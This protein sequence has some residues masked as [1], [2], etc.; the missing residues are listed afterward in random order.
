MIE[1]MYK[2]KPEDRIDRRDALKTALIV[3]G[4]FWVLLVVA[5]NCD[6]AFNEKLR[7]VLG[8]EPNGLK[9]D[10]YILLTTFQLSIPMV[11]FLYHAF[12]TLT[13]ARE[14]KS[15]GIHAGDVR[16][17]VGFVGYLRY[18]VKDT[19]EGPEIRKS[20]LITFA[21]IIYLL[22]IFVW[23]IWWTDKQGI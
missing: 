19:G 7:G 5:T 16:A 12:I 21:G 9:F 2:R 14:Y 1:K 13:H 18:L 10:L 6:T 23:W 8:E 11:F 22:G 3:A 20:K 17:F 15:P 4:L